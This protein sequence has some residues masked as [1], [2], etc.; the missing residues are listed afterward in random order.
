M[1]WACWIPIVLLLAAG[2]GAEPLHTVTGT[3]VRLPVPEGF[4]PS[5]HFA[6]IGIESDLTSVIVS[7]LSAPLSISQQ[8][9][10]AAAL[11]RNGLRLHRRAPVRVDGY[12]GLLLHAT[13]RADGLDFRK[14]LLL[15]GD[16]SSSVLVTATTP[17]DRESHHQAALIRSLQGVRYTPTPT[18]APV[19]RRFRVRAPAPLEVVTTSPNA[20]VLANPADAATEPVVSLVTVGESRTA[21]QI[22]DLAGFARLR[23]HETPSIDEIEIDNERETQLDAL[24]AHRIEARAV[25]TATDTPMRVWQ[26]LASDGEH[27]YL[28]QGL[29]TETQA[30]TLGPRFDAITESF[31]RHR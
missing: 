5:D 6:G 13:Q 22:R 17:L 24:P 1:R 16:D 7:E 30:T 31:V 15:I 18:A 2:T 28:V 4:A 9:F 29:A 14:W 20:I 3:G 11:A 19:E 12:D 21:V 26:V 25:D 8:E 27:Y 23:L 10:E